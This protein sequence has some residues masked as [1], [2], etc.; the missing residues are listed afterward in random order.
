MIP[1]DTDIV[2][3]VV[4]FSAAKFSG[5][6]IN[7]TKMIFQTM[8]DND[9]HNVVPKVREERVDRKAEGSSYLRYPRYPHQ[10]PRLDEGRGKG[11]GVTI[12]RYPRCEK[13][14]L[15]GTG[16][17][18]RGYPRYPGRPHWNP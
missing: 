10:F 1:V 16:V 15:R 14:Q 11:T 3:L 9:V 17:T 13:P 18:M 8:A 12:Q 2:F 4:H 6:G 5:N 7:D